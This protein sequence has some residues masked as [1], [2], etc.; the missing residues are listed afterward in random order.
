LNRVKKR[1]FHHRRHG[2]CVEEK[3]G[4]AAGGEEPKIQTRVLRV[5]HP[6]HPEEKF[7]RHSQNG[8]ATN[9][10]LRTWG[11]AVL[12]PY[13]DVLL[14]LDE[15]AATV[16]RVAL[17]CRLHAEGLFLAEADDVE[18]VAGNAEADEVLLDSVGTAIAESEVV[19]G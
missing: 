17:F 18:A 8:C 13:G 4:W 10:I 7:E 19:F 16:L 11:A 6:R 12:H 5:G 1:K 2:E 14:G 15:V 9:E 3:E